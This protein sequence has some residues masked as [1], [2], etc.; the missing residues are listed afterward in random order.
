MARGS[1]VARLLSSDREECEWRAVATVEAAVARSRA[2]KK[3]RIVGKSGNESRRSV[4][5]QQR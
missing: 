2:R 4:R 3:E 1:A 5:P